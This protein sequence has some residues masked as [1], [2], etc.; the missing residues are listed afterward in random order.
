MTPAA[1]RELARVVAATKGKAT[2]QRDLSVEVSARP[3]SRSSNFKTFPLA[4][5]G[6]ASTTSRWRGTLKFAMCS[7][8]HARTSS[9]STVWPAVGTTNAMP[10]SPIRA[11]GTPTI[12]TWARSGW[13][14]IRPSIS[15]GYALNPPTMNMSL[16]RSVM[17][18]LSASST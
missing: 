10:T 4:F 16:M 5:N 6:S 18:T 13:S 3:R 8:A 2:L 1:A 7:R 15:A 14:S 9:G 12:A 11:S 17:V